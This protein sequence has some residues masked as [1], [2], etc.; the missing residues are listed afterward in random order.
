MA[1]MHHRVAC[2]A[3]HR[4]LVNWLRASNEKDWP[5]RG[6]RTGTKVLAPYYVAAFRVACVLWGTC[7][8][9]FFTY[10]PYPITAR[11]IMRKEMAVVMQLIVNYHAVLHATIKDRLRR[12][13]GEIN[14]NQS[15]RQVM[16]CTQKA[17]FNKIL[18]LSSSVK[19]N[20]YLQKY[21]PSL[22]GR[23]PVAIFG[24]ILSQ[25]TV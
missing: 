11:G 4:S 5:C 18:V 6:D 19:H 7:A 24:D 10:L 3:N 13:E 14:E 8:S 12:N 25:L 20:V 17:I 15:Q 23:F 22:G 2:C 1:K 21:E 16:A 9:I